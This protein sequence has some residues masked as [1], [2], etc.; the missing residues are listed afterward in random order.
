[1]GLQY[2]HHIIITVIIVVIIIILV[3]VAIVVVVD[4]VVA[5][6][7]YLKIVINILIRPSVKK[8]WVP[9]F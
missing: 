7:F 3:V 4:V 8:F 6:C 5:F 2:V 1:M 9:H